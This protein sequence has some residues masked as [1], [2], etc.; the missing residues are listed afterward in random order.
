[1]HIAD[2]AN[3]WRGHG[4]RIV[5]EIRHPQITEQDA[6]VGMR[7]RAHASFSFGCKL[8]QFRFQSALLVEEFLWP[9]A[10]QPVFQKLEMFGMGRWIRERH[11]MRTKGSFYLQ[12]ID[13]L[14]TRPTF[15]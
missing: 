4:F 6:T 14:R 3:S 11:L 13:H 12:A 7:I 5:A 10:F 2:A 1:M 9:I 8:G 15:G